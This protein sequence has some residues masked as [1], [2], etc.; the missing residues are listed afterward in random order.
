MGIKYNQLDKIELFPLKKIPVDGGDVMHCLKNCD[1]GFNGFGEA[2]FSCIEPNSVKAWKKHL[3][4]TMNLIVPIGEVKFVFYCSESK[5][6]RVEKIG[7][8]N[9]SRIMVPPG[10]WFGFMGIDLKESL[11]LNIASCLH[12]PEEIQRLDIKKISYNWVK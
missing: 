3:K 4:M 10:I 6:F 12:D 11:V 7:E 2:Y 8:E 5:K 1:L 9:Y